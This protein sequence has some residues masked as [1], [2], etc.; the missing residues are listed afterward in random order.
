MQLR[1]IGMCE[2]MMD[3]A[4]EDGFNTGMINVLTRSNG[5]VSQHE[6]WQNAKMIMYQWS[7]CNNKHQDAQKFYVYQQAFMTCMRK[8]SSV[9]LSIMFF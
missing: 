6:I 1:K 2:V 5:T 7:L 3:K 8:I 4:M 9:K